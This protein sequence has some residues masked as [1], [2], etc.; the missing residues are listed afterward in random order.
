MKSSISQYGITWTFDT[1]CE[2]GQFCNGD[3]WVVGPVTIIGIAPASILNGGLRING[4]MLNP[5]PTV[6][7]QGFDERMPYNTYDAGLNVAVGVSSGAPLRLSAGS[8]LISTIGYD[9]P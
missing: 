3:W 6:S 1:S 5:D 4:S 2:C 8:S 9:T 7:P